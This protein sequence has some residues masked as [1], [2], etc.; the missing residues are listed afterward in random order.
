L[1][2]PSTA[3]D[4]FAEIKRPA[5]AL[6]GERRKRFD[7]ESF[8]EQVYAESAV[9]ATRAGDDKQPNGAGRPVAEERVIATLRIIERVITVTV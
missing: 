7:L 5:R 3:E 2:I 4:V 9:Q 6:A 8:I 1:R